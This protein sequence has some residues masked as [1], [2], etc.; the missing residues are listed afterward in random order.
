MKK[1]PDIKEQEVKIIHEERGQL[2]GRKIRIV[3]WTIGE[4]TFGP[5]LEKRDYKIY[6]DTVHYGRAKGFSR[7]DLNILVEN[8]DAIVEAMGG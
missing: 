7:A 8:W 1:K 4:K 2:G 5:F 6:K 3:A